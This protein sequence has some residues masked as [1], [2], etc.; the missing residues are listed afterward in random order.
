MDKY[1]YFLD[2]MG[3]R[4]DTPYGPMPSHMGRRCFGMQLV[5]GK[6]ER[7]LYRWSPKKCPHCFADNDIAARYCIECKGEIV[8]PND[9]LIADYKAMKRDPHLPQCDEVLSMEC[10]AT[11]SARSGKE[12]LRVDWVTPYRQFSGWLFPGSPEHKRFM[13]VTDNGNVKP[14][15]VGYRKTDDRFFKVHSYNLPADEA[16]TVDVVRRAG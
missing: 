4:I 3:E 15:T 1:G 8:D 10:K 13:D 9:K 11:I 12:T 16:E 7:C 5:L 14:K 6:L 2:L